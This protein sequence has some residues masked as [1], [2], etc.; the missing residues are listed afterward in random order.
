M[1][2]R[3]HSRQ[4]PP[5]PWSPGAEQVGR[6]PP[7]FGSESQETWLKADNCALTLEATKDGKIIAKSASWDQNKVVLRG[8]ALEV[9]WKDALVNLVPVA[10]P[11]EPPADEWGEEYGRVC[12]SCRAA[13]HAFRNPAEELW[14]EPGRASRFFDVSLPWTPSMFDVMATGVR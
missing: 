4:Q 6:G 10:R 11:V 12:C 5:T 3:A 8:E 13:S 7:S 2:C 9:S 1:G 14:G